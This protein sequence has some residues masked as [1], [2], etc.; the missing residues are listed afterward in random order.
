MTPRRI[1]YNDDAQ[2][3]TLRPSRRPGRGRPLR[4]EALEGRCLLSTIVWA[5]D[6][7]VPGRHDPDHFDAAFGANATRAREIVRQAI[8]AWEQVIVNF[9]Y[10]HVGQPG[11]A[12]TANTFLLSVGA[13]NLPGGETSGINPYASAV[14]RETNDLDGPPLDKYGPVGKP[15]VAS[16]ALDVNGG[17]RGWYFGLPSDDGAVFTQLVSVFSARGDL[18]GREDFYTA[19]LRAI[20]QAVG[21]STEAYHYELLGTIATPVG[22][23]PQRPQRG[24][25]GVL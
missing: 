25:R 6:G 12:P 5:N 10:T 21:I 4:L 22:A 17:G 2:R 8:Q 18:G 20:G 19:V 3:N 9:N 1:R 11:Y 16:I 23:L 14:D 13:E 15:F 24:G 7:G